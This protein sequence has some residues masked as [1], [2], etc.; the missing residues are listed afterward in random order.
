MN[1]IKPKVN[2]IHH[3]NS[4]LCD[5]QDH[6][7]HTE[8]AGQHDDLEHMPLIQLLECMNDEDQSVPRVVRNCIPAITELIEHTA[9]LMARGGRLFYIGAGTSGRLGVVDAS[10]CPPTFGIDQGRV[11]GLIAGGDQAIRQAVEFAE[12]SETAGWE[13]LTRHQINANDVVV[14]IAASGRTPYVV[15]ALRTCRKNGISTACITCNENTAV[16]EHADFPIVAVTGPEFVTGST[17]LKAGTA[18]KL[19]L[20]ML[21]TGVMIRLGRVKGNRMVDM[22]PAN[23]KLIERGIRMI[24]DATQCDLSTAASLMHEHGNVRKAIEAFEINNSNL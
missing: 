17:R 11:V 8:R 1:E 13:D 2:E 15:A 16:A 5:M 18:Q 9:A 24:M 21:S 23:N 12:D 20:N 14:G 4:D 19:I 22:M 3:S 10:E 7:P 6:L